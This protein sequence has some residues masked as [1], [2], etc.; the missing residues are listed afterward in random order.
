VADGSPADV[1][2]VK[3]VG[4]SLCPRI[5]EALGVVIMETVR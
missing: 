1:A 3:Q 5:A 4:N 2:A